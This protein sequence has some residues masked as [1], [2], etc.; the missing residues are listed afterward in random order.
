MPVVFMNDITTGNVALFE[1]APGGGD[2]TDPN[3]NRNRPLNNPLSW[4]SYVK[5]H[6]DFDY[7][8]VA[9]GPTNVT[10]THPA[11][12]ASGTANIGSTGMVSRQINIQTNTHVLVTHNLGYVPS[13]MVV[14][15]GA[16]VPPGALLAATAGQNRNVTPFAT[17]TQ[18]SLFETAIT[19]N[20]ILPAINVDYEIIV[21]RQP[22][23]ASGLH[24]REFDPVT[25][26]V[27]LG[28][29]KFD[30]DYRILRSVGAAGAGSSPFD[31]SLGPTLDILN[32]GVRYV[33][34]NGTT[35]SDPNYNGSFTGSPNIQC[36]V[37]QRIK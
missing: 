10:I 34:A 3:S 28:Y 4:L 26:R 17:T 31:I 13:Y 1:E 19:G 12:A 33:S 11:L 22:A 7:Y 2:V 24:E 9:M 20:S 18:I 15:A 8:Q 16:I 37:T 5:F 25:G 35:R 29:E 27:T 36:A 14:T 32:G 21:F 30:S 23:S 6:P